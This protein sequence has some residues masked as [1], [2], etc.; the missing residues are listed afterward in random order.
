MK[1]RKTRGSSDT[2]MAPRTILVLK[3]DPSCS[4]RRSIHR[5]TRARP[6]M[7]PKTRSAATINVFTAKRTIFSPQVRGSNGTLSEPRVITAASR[8][9]KRTPP[10]TRNSRELRGE[11]LIVKTLIQQRSRELEL[12]RVAYRKGSSYHT[13]QDIHR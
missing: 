6:R 5:R 9:A 4:A 7:S 3:R 12:R 13:E 2:A 1:N 8:R 10:R 11:S